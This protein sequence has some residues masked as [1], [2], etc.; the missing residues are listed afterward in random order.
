MK[1]DKAYLHLHKKKY[2][3]NTA[4]SSTILI[5]VKPSWAEGQV[6]AAAQILHLDSTD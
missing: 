5:T 2:E 4:M 6:P 3:M 1:Q